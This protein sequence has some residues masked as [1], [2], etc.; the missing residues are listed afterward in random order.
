MKM[1]SIKRYFQ[2][3]LAALVASIAISGLSHAAHPLDFLSPEQRVFMMNKF[4]E[5]EG[6]LKPNSKNAGAS[7][8]SGAAPLTPEQRV[9]VLNWFLSGK[10]GSEAESPGMPVAAAPAA[11]SA[12][13]KATAAINMKSESDLAASFGKWTALAKGVKFERFRD[14]FSIDGTRYLDPEGQITAY[15]FDEQSGDF[16]YLVQK[17]RGSFLLKTGRASI[18]EEPVEIGTVNFRNGLWNVTTITGKKF[19]GKRIIP[20]ARGFITARDNTGYRYV[21]GAGAT[22]FAAPEEFSIAA[23]QSGN[24]SGTGFILLERNPEDA[25]QPNNSLSALIGSVKAL[26]STLG[27]GKK[28]DYALLNMDNRKL[29]PVNISID[30]KR[31]QYLSTCRRVNIFMSECERMDSY[32]SLFQPNGLPN[33]THYFW[34]INWF[35]ASGRPVL[36][37]QEGGLTKVAATDMESGKKVVLFERMMGIASF[38][39]TQGRDG[40]ISVTAQMGLST[41]KKDDVVALIDSDGVLPQEGK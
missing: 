31:V 11:L 2:P 38:T 22:S 6:Q 40:R 17:E 19:S 33:M 35:N 26:G 14:G 8:G 12:S 10:T 9:K 37:S 5:A 4:L 41:E 15:G 18:T 3:K 34:R 25:G 24:V 27:V 28:E 30:D 1:N 32:E 23:L 36:V 21:P 13:E 20:L 7:D 29:F 39:P 16:T